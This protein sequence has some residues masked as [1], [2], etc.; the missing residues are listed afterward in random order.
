LFARDRFNGH[1]RWTADDGSGAD[2]SSPIVANGVVYIG[3]HDGAVRAFADAGGNLLWSYQ[4]GGAIE[5]SP[6]LADGRLYVT[7]NDGN[8]YAFA[9]P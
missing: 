2:Y 4:T 9:L 1:F 5:S 8:L 6:A 7:S 3:S